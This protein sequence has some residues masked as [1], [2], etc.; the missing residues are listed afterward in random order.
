MAQCMTKVRLARDYLTRALRDMGYTVLPTSTN[1]FIFKVGDAH[2]F[3]ERLLKR[4]FLVR[5]CTS[6]GLPEYVRLAPGNW[7]ECRQLIKAITE[8]RRR[9]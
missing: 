7:R 2:D 5:D 1:F 4:G 6:F 9:S 3:R 8:I